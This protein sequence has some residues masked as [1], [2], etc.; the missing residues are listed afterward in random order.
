MATEERSNDVNTSSETANAASV[1][2]SDVYLIPFSC[3]PGSRAI[4]ITPMMGRRRIS[5]KYG[6][7]TY[8]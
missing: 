2:T 8:L 7:L 5:V 4:T 3:F 6:K 1:K